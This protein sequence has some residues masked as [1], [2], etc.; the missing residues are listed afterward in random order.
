MPYAPMHLFGFSVTAD[1]QSGAITLSGNYLSERFTDSL[2]LGVV[3]EVFTLN[4]DINQTFNGF[5]WYISFK[6]MLNA[7][8]TLIDGYPMPNGSIETGIKYNIT[9]LKN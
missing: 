4:L 8:Y 1:W 5:T 2:N 3:P 6:N 7:F 9:K